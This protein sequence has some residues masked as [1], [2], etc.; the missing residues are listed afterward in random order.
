MN[1]LMKDGDGEVF[2]G[3]PLCVHV[4]IRITVPPDV[5]CMSLYWPV[6]YRKFICS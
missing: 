6:T 1:L 3:N 5:C 4:E 2:S